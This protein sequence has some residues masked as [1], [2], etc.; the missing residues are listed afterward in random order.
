MVELPAV[1][2]AGAAG[3]LLAEAMFRA[4]PWPRV[5][6]LARRGRQ[7]LLLVA[8]CIPLILAAALLESLVARAPEWLLS[9]GLRLAVAGVV[10][11]L[12]AVYVLLL[13]WGRWAAPEEAAS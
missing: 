3:F 6:E 7:A 11:L 10:A 2:I 13:G 1:F 9:T 12:F 5:E 4:R 8:G